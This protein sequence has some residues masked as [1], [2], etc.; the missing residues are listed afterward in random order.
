MR[1][2]SPINSQ[3]HDVVNG[4]VDELDKVADESHNDEAHADH[5]ADLDVL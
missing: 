2:A 4:D 3:T 5:P 1:L